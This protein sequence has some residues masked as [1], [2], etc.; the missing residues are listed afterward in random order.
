MIGIVLC[1]ISVSLFAKYFK[2]FLHYIPL[3][4]HYNFLM[5]SHYQFRS[6]FS[7]YPFYFHLHLI[8]LDNMTS[9][10]HHDYGMMVVG[11]N[12]FLYKQSCII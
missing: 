11:Q 12:K 6:F 3:V 5:P 4:W 10:K 2:D 8:I 7:P 9:L 1:S